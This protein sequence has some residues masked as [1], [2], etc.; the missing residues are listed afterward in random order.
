MDGTGRREGGGRLPPQ[1]PGAGRGHERV[2][3]EWVSSVSA[4]LPGSP[5]WFHKSSLPPPGPRGK[6]SGARER[7]VRDVPS[8]PTEGPPRR[9]DRRRARAV[10]VRPMGR[11]DVRR[12]R[13]PD[14]ER[15]PGESGR[16]SAHGERSPRPLTRRTTLRARRRG[17]GPGPHSGDGRTVRSRGRAGR[18]GMSGG[19]RHGPP[20]SKDGTRGRRRGR[21]WGGREAVHWVIRPPIHPRLT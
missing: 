6:V 8:P 11:E 10:G 3:E 1:Q 20:R 18:P 21:R 19:S 4:Q 2:G 12:E 7:G 14:R 15:G 5:S 17:P 9:P 16:A 13:A